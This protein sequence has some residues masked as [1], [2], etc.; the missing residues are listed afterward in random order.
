[1]PMPPTAFLRPTNMSRRK[2]EMAIAQEV[3][4]ELLR[5]SMI[6]AVQIDLSLTI[7]RPSASAW[8]SRSTTPW[9]DVCSATS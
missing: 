7:L 5:E 1:M 6:E 9:W 8:A 4:D 2:R 3:A